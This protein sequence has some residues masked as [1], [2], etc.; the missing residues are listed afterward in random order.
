MGI[1]PDGLNPLERDYLS[2]LLSSPGPVALGRLA[3][4]LGTSEKTL[5]LE[6]EPFLFRRGLVGMTPRGRVAIRRPRLAAPRLS[7]RPDKPALSGR[8]DNLLSRRGHPGLS[9]RPDDVVV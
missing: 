8:P 7:G 5:L 6:T 9:G 3:R 2:L 4:M 1:D